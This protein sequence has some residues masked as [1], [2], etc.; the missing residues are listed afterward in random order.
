MSSLHQRRSSRLSTD[1]AGTSRRRQPGRG[2]SDGRNGWV[3]MAER[4]RPGPAFA[5]TDSLPITLHGRG[6]HASRKARSTRSSR[7]PPRCCGCRP[8]CRERLQEATPSW[9]PCEPAT[10]GRSQTSSRPRPIAAQRAQLQP[11]RAARVLDVIE[12]IVA[13]EAILG[14]PRCSGTGGQQETRIGHHR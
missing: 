12:R 11:R 14:H 10:P 1:Q 4:G 3:A 2:A 6:G 13:A 5:P 7:L 8:W 9:S